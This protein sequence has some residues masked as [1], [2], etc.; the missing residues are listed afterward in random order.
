MPVLT[1]SGGES[2]PSDT[3]D[4]GATVDGADDAAIAVQTKTSARSSRTT[5]P[6]NNLVFPDVIENAAPTSGRRQQQEGSSGRLDDQPDRG[7]PTLSSR[8]NPRSIPLSA[9]KYAVAD[10]NATMDPNHNAAPN[11]IVKP[12]DAQRVPSPG[13]ASPANARSA[14]SRHRQ[15]LLQFVPSRAAVRGSVT[16]LARELPIR[17]KKAAH[18]SKR[19]Y[20]HASVQQ[21]IAYALVISGMLSEAFTPAPRHNTPLGVLLFVVPL[22]QF[23]HRLVVSGLCAGVFIDIYWLL[24]PQEASFNGY[25]STNFVSAAQLALAAC[26][27]V[28][29]WL[30]F[31]AYSDLQEVEDN[32]EEVASKRR[33]RRATTSPLQPGSH[34]LWD[35]IKYIFPRKTM[36]KRSHL[37]FEVLMRVLA[38]V[39]IHGVL[40]VLLLVLALI[41]ASTYQTRPQFRAKPL[42]LPL[43]IIMLFK[44]GTTLLSYFCVTHQMSYRGCLGLTVGGIGGFRANR[45]DIV[46]KYNKVWVQ[47]V[48]RAKA[49]DTVAGV[50]AL[51]ALFMASHRGEGVATPGV[52]AV[53][54]FTAASL[55]MLELWTPLLILT[56][57]KCGARLHD[58]H[59]LG[60]DGIDDPYFPNQIQ[61][62]DEEEGSDDDS[63]DGDSDE[64]D[65][66]SG[67]GE[68][69]SDGDSTRRV[70]AIS[71]RERQRR[72][73]RGRQSERSSRRLDPDRRPSRRQLLREEDEEEDDSE[74]EDRGWNRSARRSS[75]AIVD[76]NEAP[77][78][79]GNS[80]VDKPAMSGPIWVRHLDPSSGRPFLVHSITGESVWEIVSPRDNADERDGEDSDDTERQPKTSARSSR[81]AISRVGSSRS[82]KIGDTTSRRNAEDIP[83]QQQ[84]LEQ[85]APLSQRD[86]SELATLVM[87]TREWYALGVDSGAFSCRVSR[88]P[89][90]S[91]LTAHLT[92]QGF[93]VVSDGIL[94]STS[95]DHR[96]VARLL[97]PV[98][99]GEEQVLFLSEFTFDSLSLTLRAAFRCAR[100]DAVVEYVRRLQLKEIVGAYSPIAAGS[101]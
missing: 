59:R 5:T 69:D 23:P 3:T 87:F 4:G 96:R 92:R 85:D 97:A 61:W 82:S 60:E 95:G 86:E 79:V 56:A 26:A 67:D 9:R 46:L 2:L 75:L 93:T 84:Q 78:R 33:G 16:L 40:G 81:R 22:A 88:I 99:T 98:Y 24:R 66:S 51:L 94:D 73:T 72:S 28:K 50:Y 101:G 58:L 65:D 52:E 55:F 14:S 1:A 27:L 37:S 41:A 83:Q 39:W 13:P 10:S 11:S 6:R 19:A 35:Q 45:N 57:A 63:D 91:E 21:I 71:L 38:L 89:S 43:H 25:F 62:S 54:A 47:R 29:L 12:S 30:L 100:V 64:D 17:I 68:E 48:Q 32:V 49:L 42:G 20:D 36:P 53:L 7:A 15:S 8:S 74:E 76:A 34:R 80:L 90:S 70:S 77:R 31:S 44:A 18:S